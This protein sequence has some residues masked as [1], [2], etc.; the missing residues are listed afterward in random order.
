MEQRFEKRTVPCLRRDLWQTQDREQT[1]EVRLSDGMPDIGNVLSTRGQCVLRSKEWLGDSI[2]VSG[3]IMVWIV[4]APADGTEP[5]TI[6]T[7]IPVQVKWNLPETQREGSIRASF[8][9]RSIDG[10]SISARK[11]MVRA[12]LSAL[13]EVMEPWEAEVYTPA[14]TTEDVQ[15]LR[16]TYPAVLPMESG[17]KTFLVDET[18]TLP[19]GSPAVEKLVCFELRP[20]VMERKV[21]GGKAVFRG[22]AQLHLCYRGVDGEFYAVDLE[23]PFS[24]FSDLD[25]DYDK[26]ATLSVMMA[27]TNVEPELQEGSLHLKCGLVAQYIVDDCVILELVEDAYSPKREVQTRKEELELP[28]VLDRCMETARCQA[29]LNAQPARIVDVWACHGQPKIRRAGDLTELELSGTMGVLYRDAEGR[30]QGAT[31]PWSEVVEHPAAEETM[32]LGEM[33]EVSRPAATVGS[34]Q[35][36]MKLELTAQTQTVARQ[37]LAMVTAL[38]LGEAAAPDP[39]RP[40]LILRRAGEGS[41]WELAKGSGSTVDAIRKANGLSDEPLDDRILLIPVC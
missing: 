38:E 33:M 39:A 25:R 36:E 21:L 12:V 27:V 1:Q 19:A 31:S 35:I 13:A 18:L 5:Q 26:D 37:G 16:R 11:L 34:E 23:A 28:M 32:V 2:S 9:L 10:R 4:Y 24:Q 14:E 29:A 20:K 30:M 3:G 6:E 8:S 22:D 17:E 15:L 7:W 41:L 40:S